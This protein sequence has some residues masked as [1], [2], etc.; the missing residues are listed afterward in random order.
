MCVNSIIQLWKRLQMA[1]FLTKKK[2]LNFKS[3]GWTPSRE[4]IFQPPWLQGTRTTTKSGSM[5]WLSH[6][7]KWNY[8]PNIFSYP[9]WY[10]LK[11]DIVM[12]GQHWACR[13]GVPQ[14]AGK[15]D[16]RNSGSKTTSSN[17][18]PSLLDYLPVL[19][20]TW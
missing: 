14:M 17:S 16:R 20:L 19:A 10:R 5:R 8:I 15:Q 12:L 4:H 9:T 6:V 11:S 1:F 7:I 18:H 13:R 3:S 2:N